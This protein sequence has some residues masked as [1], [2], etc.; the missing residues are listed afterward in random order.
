VLDAFGLVDRLIAYVVDDPAPTPDELAAALWGACH[1][2]QQAVAR[3]LLDRGADVN[4]IAPWDG[5]TPLDAAARSEHPELVE[6]LRLRAA[7]PADA[8]PS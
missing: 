1:G 4:W 3:Y 5:L 7:L 8:L 6:W 2:G